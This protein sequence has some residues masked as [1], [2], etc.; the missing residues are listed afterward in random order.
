MKYTKEQADAGCKDIAAQLIDDNTF[1]NVAFGGGRKNFLPNTEHDYLQ[2]GSMGLRID[3]RNLINDWA[4]SQEQMKK[5][6]KFL[7]N[8]TELRN[9]DT[10]KYD[11]YL[12]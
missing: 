6:Y 5:K 8:A 10:E 3:N 1:I 4:K 12:G 7:W 9:L 2:N 11:H